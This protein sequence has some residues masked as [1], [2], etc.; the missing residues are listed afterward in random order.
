MLSRIIDELCVGLLC[1]SQQQ[2][3]YAEQQRVVG[4]TNMKH[5]SDM[6]E[7][8][9]YTRTNSNVAKGSR[10]FEKAILQIGQA[11]FPESHC[12]MQRTW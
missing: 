12:F 7:Y 5:L 2:C 6:N 3:L 4:R 10:G 8:K 9:Y 1:F 11:F